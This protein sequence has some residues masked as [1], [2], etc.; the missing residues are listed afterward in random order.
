[1]SS[2]SNLQQNLN[3][4]HQTWDFDNVDWDEYESHRPP[5]SKALYDIIYEHHQAHGGQWNTAL[6][7]GAG[8]GVV[9][10]VLL[11]SFDHVYCSD[12]SATYL[13]QAKA[14]FSKEAEAGRVSFLQRKFDEFDTEKDLANTG[15]V[16]L[17][18]A[19]TCIHFSKPAV[20]MSQLAPLLHIGGT[21]TAFTY[22]ATPIAPPG[23]PAGPLIS[24]TKNKLMRYVHENII[25]IDKHEGPGTIQSRYHNVDFD[26]ETW[27]NVRRIT[28]VPEAQNYPDWMQPAVSRVREGESSDEV[29]GEDTITRT[30]GFEF[31]PTMFRNIGPGLDIEEVIKDELEE[32]KRCMGEERILL[33]WPV[34]L[35]VATK[36]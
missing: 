31:F 8:G 21:V 25:P 4:R 17:I 18:T 36:K 15:P 35:V 10:R 16:D 3:P 6:D 20:L 33:R 23:H 9:T 29:V 2:S 30:V 11:N 19:G 7:V 1:M 12:S 26:P 22:G 27:T 34:I 32:L 14:R 24:K 5:Y 13:A 28:S